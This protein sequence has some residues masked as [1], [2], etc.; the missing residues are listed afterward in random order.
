MSHKTRVE[1]SS[2]YLVLGLVKRFGYG[3]LAN[4]AC[5]HSSTTVR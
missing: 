2:P 3:N 1:E 5:A 4:P